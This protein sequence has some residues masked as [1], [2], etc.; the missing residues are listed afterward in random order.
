MLDYFKH[1]TVLNVYNYIANLKKQPPMLPLLRLLLMQGSVS[2]VG[3]SDWFCSLQDAH[4]RE[5]FLPEWAHS[6]R[7]KLIRFW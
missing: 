6:F 5:S 4:L 7:Y 2:Q 1:T 3:C